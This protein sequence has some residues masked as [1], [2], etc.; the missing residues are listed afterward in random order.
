MGEVV[1]EDEEATE[2]EED[3]AVLRQS[4]SSHKDPGFH[5]FGT[6]GLQRLQFQ[7]NLDGNQASIQ[8]RTMSFPNERLIPALKITRKK[9]PSS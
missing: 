5:R 9:F 1:K 8:R 6:N 2:V 7:L 3:V 4:F